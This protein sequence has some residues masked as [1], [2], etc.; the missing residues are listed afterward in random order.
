MNI[1]WHLEAPHMWVSCKFRIF[2]YTNI[3]RF[4]FL[5]KPWTNIVKSKELYIAK[6]QNVLKIWMLTF[7][8]IIILFNILLLTLFIIEFSTSI[9]EH[10]MNLN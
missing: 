2:Q 5:I 3:W 6:S 9:D 7:K 4:Y 8:I 1:Y 10:L